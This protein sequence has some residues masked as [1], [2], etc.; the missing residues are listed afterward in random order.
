MKNPFRKRWEIRVRSYKGYRLQ[1]D[2]QGWP[3]AVFWFWKNAVKRSTEMAQED[4]AERSVF[5]R[6]EEPRHFIV[7]RLP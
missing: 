2:Y 5:A 3:P 6:F 1:R 4:R 7:K